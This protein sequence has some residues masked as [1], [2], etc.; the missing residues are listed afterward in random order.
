MS[1]HSMATDSARSRRSVLRRSGAALAATAA[2]A[3]CS[4]GESTETE[5]FDGP[6]VDVGPS[7]RNTF[8]PGTE[9]PLRIET[10]TTVRWVWDS[11]NHNI[12]VRE[13]PSAADWDG[14]GINNT[15]HSYEYTFEVAGEYHYVCEP[16]E[17]LGMTAD[18][19][20]E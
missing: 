10:G 3:G 12:V 2:L 17:G 4:S 9:E 7:G 11:T 8:S 14:E 19:I 15:G 20:V 16:H 13:Q 18:L 6:V 1:D 5:P